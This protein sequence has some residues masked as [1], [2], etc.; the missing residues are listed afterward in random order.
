M[1]NPTLM[2][3]SKLHYLSKTPSP[4]TITLGVRASTYELG[5]GHNS[6]HIGYIR[7]NILMLL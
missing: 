5:E 3:S 1:R 2:T 6:F 4:H 7:E